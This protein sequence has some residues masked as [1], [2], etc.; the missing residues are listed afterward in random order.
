MLSEESDQNASGEHLQLPEE[1]PV[2]YKHPSRLSI[3]KTVFKLV[4][5]VIRLRSDRREWVRKEGQSIDE[6]KF[7]NHAEKALNAFISL[8]PSYIKLGQWLSS[9]SDI[10]P[11]PYLDVFSRLQDDVPAAP[12]DEI[13]KI[14]ERELGEIDQVFESFDNKSYFRG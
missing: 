9:R 7:K 11:Q 2:K 12:F 4:P 14:I 5:L 3:L 8:G 13:R 1:L 6:N 10:L